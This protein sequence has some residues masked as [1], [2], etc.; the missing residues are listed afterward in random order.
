MIKANARNSNVELLRLVCMFFV[1]CFHFTVFGLSLN[2]HKGDTIWMGI[3][4][5]IMS[6]MFIAVNCFVLI[7]GYFGI[8][9]KIKGVVNLVFTAAV[10]FVAT[11]LLDFA[12]IGGR[13]GLSIREL[14]LGTIFPVSHSGA[15]F[16]KCYFGLYLFSPLLNKGLDALSKKEYILVLILFTIANEYLGYF[17]KNDAF[18]VDGFNIS[19][20]VYLYIIGGYF[21]RF[22]TQQSI[23][24]RKWMWI[25]IYLG[26]AVVYAILSILGMNHY[27]PHWDGWKYNN[28]VLIIGAMSFL[29]FFLCLDFK[30]GV[31]NK[32]AASCL[33]IYLMQT[34]ILFNWVGE[35]INHLVCSNAIAELLMVP[36]FALA[37]MAIVILLDQIR[38]MALKP[39]NRLCK[40]ADERLASLIS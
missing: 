2:V 35:T 6:L 27:V 29:L 26:A 10:C 1:L 19:Q 40:K 15:W 14:V 33:A 36:P 18:N 9:F 16:L 21:K 23:S 32:L 4:W 13:N 31:V 39:V 34:G 8:K 12:I 25:V 24:Q 28:P 17:W 38:L 20:F 37:F 30:S 5:I 22:V 3:Q 7:S 11:K